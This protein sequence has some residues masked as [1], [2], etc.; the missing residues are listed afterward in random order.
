MAEQSTPKHERAT[1]AE[2]TDSED[3]NARSRKR[4]RTGQCRGCRCPSEEVGSG[5]GEG[6]PGRRAPQ[7]RTGGQPQ[8]EAEDWRDKYLRLH[9]EWDTYRRRMKEQR[10]EEERVR[11]AEKLVESLI[12]VIDDFERTI[13]YAE[14]RREGL[15]GG[16]KAVHNKIGEVLEEGRSGGHQP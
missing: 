11:A 4:R 8:A 1:Q 3:A 12:P 5:K 2:G 9:A 7:G 16:V 15:I 10:E 6:R 13:A 14:E